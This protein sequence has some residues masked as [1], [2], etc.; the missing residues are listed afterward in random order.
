MSFNQCVRQRTKQH[1][2]T[3]GKHR[4]TRGCTCQSADRNRKR[5]Q[6]RGKPILQ[7]FLRNSGECLGGSQ[8]RSLQKRIVCSPDAG[9][10]RAWI[11]CPNAVDARQRTMDSQHN[12]HEASEGRP[13]RHRFTHLLRSPLRFASYG[14]GVSR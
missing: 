9:V 12:L 6:R 3:I 7:I 5:P 1:E 13:A 8:T 14:N 2:H 10:R 4:R 11:L